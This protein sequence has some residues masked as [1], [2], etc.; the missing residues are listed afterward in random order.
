[1][2]M[3][4]GAQTVPR[5]DLIGHDV[6]L[7]SRISDLADAGELMVS[8]GT[9]EAARQAGASLEF[10]DMGPT[11]VRASRTRCTSSGLCV[12][13]SRTGVRRPD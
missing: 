3:H 13:S 4:W 2:G 6:N 7:A 12:T 8:Q 9:V 10:D 11:L 5:D 1:M